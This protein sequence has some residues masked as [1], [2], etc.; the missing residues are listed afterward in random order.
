[1]KFHLI[2]SLFVSYY[3]ANMEKS[4]IGVNRSGI[5][6]YSN[7]HGVTVV[8]GLYDSEYLFVGAGICRPWAT[9]SRPY[10]LSFNQ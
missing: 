8:Y 9:N 3:N 1:M 4:Q 2:S 7:K 6:K 5:V 10:I